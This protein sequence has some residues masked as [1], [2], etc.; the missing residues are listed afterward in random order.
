M[1]ASCREVSSSRRAVAADEKKSGNVTLAVQA[2]ITI[3]WY[4]PFTRART[5]S[6][7]I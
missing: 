4:M 5:R 3:P 7:R 1:A 6:R 2:A